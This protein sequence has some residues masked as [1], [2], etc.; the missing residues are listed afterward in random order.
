MSNTIRSVLLID[1]D[2]HTQAIFELLMSHYQ[3]DFAIAK[4][5]EEGL[6]YLQH[7]TPDVIVLDLFMPSIDGY[8]A[9]D[10]IRKMALN[11]ACP[12]VATTAYYTTETPQEVA[13]RG[14]DGY[15]S[16]PF[17]GSSFLKY[18]TNVVNQN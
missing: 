2:Y 3:L 11:P 18:L 1:D 17:D 10:R 12:V 5:A 4:S 8:Q 9:L 14:F 13:A 16:K 15:I 6:A 7:N